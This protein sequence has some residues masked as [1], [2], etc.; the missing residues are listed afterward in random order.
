MAFSQWGFTIV[1]VEEMKFRFGSFV[2]TERRPFLFSKLK[3]FLAEAGKSKFI[4]S[5]VIDGSFS[6]GSTNANDID[7]IIVVAENLDFSIDLSPSDYNLLSKNRVRRR[8]GF[9]VLVAP[10][11]SEQYHRYVHFFQQIRFEPGRLK[12][13]LRM[14]L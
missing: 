8:F 11:N 7:L 13:I 9:D 1:P 14:K 2:D 3:E 6:D 5:I 4:V 12:G 10:D